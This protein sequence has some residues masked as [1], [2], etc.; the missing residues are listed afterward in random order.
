[1]RRCRSRLLCRLRFSTV[2]SSS[3]SDWPH[4]SYRPPSPPRFECPSRIRLLALD[5]RLLLLPLPPTDRFR[6]A[7]PLEVLQAGGGEDAALAPP[8]LVGSGVFAPD[9]VVE[10][11]GVG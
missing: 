10:L 7:E 2:S 4:V 5:E 11:A 9:I 6:D 1:M 3:A 8:L